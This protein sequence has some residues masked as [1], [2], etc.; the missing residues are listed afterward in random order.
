MA[1]YM[2]KKNSSIF[3]IKV[4]KIEPFPFHFVKKNGRCPYYPLLSILGKMLT[5]RSGKRS[6]VEGSER[7]RKGVR[8]QGWKIS[9]T[10]TVNPFSRGDLKEF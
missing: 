8:S 10:L 2:Y 7:N 6:K 1:E 3:A 5:G 9:L 4:K